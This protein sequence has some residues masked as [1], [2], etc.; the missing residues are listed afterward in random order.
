ML[1]TE[2]DGEK[3]S[4]TMKQVWWDSY[5]LGGGGGHL[6]VEI[7]GHLSDLRMCGIAVLGVVVCGIAVLGVVVCGIAVLG[8]VVCC[9]LVCMLHNFT[10]DAHM[11]A[12][13]LI[14]PPPP[15]A[16]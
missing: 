12:L 10:I 3:S 1:E 6:L 4:F 15:P 8:V 14:A 11:V 9:I 16:L 5:W 2:F 13:N 7:G